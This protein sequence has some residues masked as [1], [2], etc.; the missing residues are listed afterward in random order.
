M[1]TKC[2]KCQFDN[3]SDS[4]F[5]KE[6]GTQLIPS[7]GSQVSK[8]MT[9]ETPVEGLTRGSLFAGRY[10]IIEE[11]GT[12]G[13]GSV[14]RAE[15]TKIRQEV[16]LKLIRPEIASSRRTIER[17]RNE[18]K[19][20]RMIAHRNVCRMFDLG[21]EKGTYF[22]TMEYVSGEDMKSFLRRAAPLS[23]GRAIS[24]GKQICEG[25][26]EA[27]RL[28]VTHRDLKPGNIMIDKEGNARIMDFGIARSIA[29]K[30]ITGTGVMIGT[31]EYMSPEQAEGKEADQRSDIYSLGVI[32]FEMVTCRLPFEGETALSIAHKHRYEPAPDPRT[33]NSQVPKDFAMLI[34][35]CLEKDKET[36]YQTVSEVQQDLEK[37]E[38]Q[39]PSTDRATSTRRPF[40]SKEITV[41]FTPKKLLIPALALILIVAAAWIF[42]IRGRGN[43]KAASAPS[44]NSIA[45]LPFTD[46]SQEKDQAVY[47]EGIAQWILDSLSNVKS[48]QVL[49]RY[50][51]FQFTGQDDPRVVGK[52][53]NADKIL[54]GS[55]WKSGDRLRITVS[56]VDA[57]TGIQDWSEPF[58]GE[59]REAIF[60][61]QDRIASTIL[62]RLNVELS[63]DDRSRLEKR[64]TGN[65]EAYDLYLKGNYAAKRGSDKDVL[66]AVP[67][68]LEAIRE[69][70]NFVLAHIALARCYRDLAIGYGVWPKEKS[71]NLTKEALEKVF[72]LDNENGEAFAIRGDLKLY[73]ESDP[74]AAELDYQRAFQLSP[75]NPGILKDHFRYLV[76]KGRM[77]EALSEAKIL[78][79]IDPLDPY[80]SWLSGL[81]Y[82]FLR[83]Y[84]DSIGAY[85]KALDLDP[86]FMS[87]QGWSVFAYLAQG[88]YEKARDMAKRFEHEVPDQ[89]LFSMAVIEGSLGNREAAEKYKR[90][91]D[92]YKASYQ[93]AGFD[94]WEAAYSAVMGERDQ[95]LAHLT[96]Y[97]A[98]NPPGTVNDLFYWHY[99]D[100]YRSDPEFIAV[101]KKAGFEMK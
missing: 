97:I 24:I 84:D 100:K 101:F 91:L 69:D 90:S 28:E 9:L 20:A 12:G 29:E 4:K 37:I 74:S 65:P 50:S 49:A 57:A 14:Y 60:D 16:A 26:A 34:L 66:R 51:S 89:Y 35:R 94:I 23:P 21:E 30:G 33:L 8:T 88:Q 38:Q 62:S 67:F 43:R 15:D 63:V 25:L 52:R 98:E 45:V 59:T 56:M 82:Y 40:T 1:A 48:L 72:A 78:I 11:L 96:R 93:G 42:L 17:F 19:T 44:G 18:I 86:D 64:P 46:L 5:C 85:R 76:T 6:C 55:L 32:L 80:G 61:I 73:Y 95:M 53:L 75:R 58:E 3:T 68:Y 27:H 41:K 39:I 22:I 77:N 81:V 71:Y 92:E 47:C 54:T 2:P 13:M 10:E 7:A 31:P 99:F 36:R 79:E 70:P 87:A 83:R